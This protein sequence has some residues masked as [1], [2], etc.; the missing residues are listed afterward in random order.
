M[1]RESGEQYGWRRRKQMDLTCSGVSNDDEFE[2]K[3]PIIAH[4]GRSFAALGVF[5]RIAQLAFQSH[6]HC[7]A[8]P[9]EACRAP[10]LPFEGPESGV[11]LPFGHGRSRRGSTRWTRFA[12]RGSLAGR[13]REIPRVLDRSLQLQAMARQHLI[14]APQPRALGLRCQPI[15]VQG[16]TARAAQS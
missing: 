3:I 13:P 7:S 4:V 6:R 16:R 10:I 1:A 2:E 5:S 9:G 11:R 15:G 14:R 12:G 8:I